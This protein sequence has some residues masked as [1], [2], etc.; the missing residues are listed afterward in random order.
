MA[1]MNRKTT[2]LLSIAI[3]A[4]AIASGLSVLFFLN[5]EG[6]VDT[7]LQNLMDK[8]N[9]PSL[10]AGIVLNDT[11][12]W[13]KGYGEQSDLDTVYMVGSVSKVF[14]ATAMMQLYDKG[15]VDLDAD[16]NDYIPFSVRNPSFPNTAITVRMLLTHSPGLAT[17]VSN[18]TLW[19]LD[20]DSLKWSN[21]YLGTNFTIL[22]SRPLLGEFLDES[23]NPSGAYYS[24]DNWASQPGTKFEYSN[25]GFLLLGYIVEQITNQPLPE[26]VQQNILTPLDMQSTG[27]DYSDFAG[28]NAVPYDLKDN[29]LFE[30]PLYNSY[31]FGAAG[32]RSTVS[33]LSNFLIAHMNEG[34]YKG[35]H[36]LQPETVYLMQTSQFTYFNQGLGWQLFPGIIGHGGSVVGYRAFIG[37]KIVDNGKVG[38]VFMINRNEL[39]GED[40]YLVDTVFHA[41]ANV[42]FN[43]ATRLA[44]T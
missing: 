15:L 42:L 9:V 3:L 6:N 34:G 8:G 30:L 1:H 22:D 37:F 25:A 39:L 27:Y 26:Y 7:K 2:A 11:L 13:S 17:D 28:R 19:D 36:I 33:D 40:K 20:A 32:L 5:Q 41:M 12:V 10:A 18:Q 21:D 38:I 16:I 4:V 35:S 31:N 24:S 44:S 23:L 14:M 43:E 29:E